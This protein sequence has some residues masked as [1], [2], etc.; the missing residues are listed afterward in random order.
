[1]DF[2]G[3]VTRIPPRQR[4]TESVQVKERVSIDATRKTHRQ[5]PSPRAPHTSALTRSKR[6]NTERRRPSAA[7]TKLASVENDAASH[8]S[9]GHIAVLVLVLGIIKGYMYLS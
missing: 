7:L 4:N 6:P 2:V 9:S 5:A 1:M 3:Y 8:P